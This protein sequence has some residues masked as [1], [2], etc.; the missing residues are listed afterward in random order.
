MTG[1]GQPPAVP[2]A[3]YRV[4][5]NAQ[6]TFAD[7][8]ALV[9]YLAR[10]GISHLYLSPFLAARTGSAHG[11]DIVDHNAFNPEL[12]GGEGFARLADT[13][14]RHG[15]GLIADFV[16]N[17]M[18]IA[19]ADNPWWLDMLEWGE[20]SPCAGYFDI[21]WHPQKPEL[22]GKVLLPFLGQPY[23]A[24]LESGQLRL[25]FDGRRGAFDVWYHE[26]RFP[27]APARFSIVLKPAAA[28]LRDSQASD[29]A[30]ALEAIANRLRA[31]GARAESAVRR[32]AQRRL[33][34]DVKAELAR[35]SAGDSRVARAIE[36]A[37]VP[38]NGIAGIP[39]SF[40]TL[41]RL[42]EA[43]VYRLS[44]WRVATHEINYRRFFDIND[45][46]GLRIEAPELFDDV[47]RLIFR[48]IADGDI[49]GLRIDHIDGLYDPRGYCDDLQ[50][51]IAAIRHAPDDGNATPFY[52]VVEKILAR[53]EFLREDWPV[54]G[55]TGYE[56][57]NLVNGLFVDPAA[58]RALTR[59]YRHV[60]RETQDFDE[61]LYA[62]K[63]HVIE[64]TLAAELR[65]LGNM[66]D[67]LSES[68]WTTRDFTRSGL[69]AALAE[70]VAC[71]PVYRTYVTARGIRPED[72]RDID[73]AVGAARR[74]NPDLD[75]SIFDFIH[76]LMTLDV[77][78]ARP[79]LFPRRAVIE[80]AMKLQ[81]YTGPVMAKAMEDTAFYR[82]HRLVSLN[83]V[84]GDPRQF[85]ISIAAFHHH[86]LERQRRRPYAML[87][88]A[89][90]D[91][92]RGEDTRT[93]ID[94]LTE[95]PAEWRSR[96][97][98]WTALNRR[99]KEM[100]D[101]RAVPRAN[102][103]YL[104]YQTLIG[105]WPS[106]LLEQASPASEQV[107]RFAERITAYMTKAVREAKRDS[108]WA[109]P[110]EPYEAA[111]GRFVDAIL[112]TT[113]PNPFLADF[114]AFQARI[115]RIGAIS[116]L[117]QTAI[118]VTAPGVPDSYRGG[119]LWDLS[120]VDPDNRRPVDY[121]LRTR[122]LDALIPPAAEEGAPCAALIETW[123]DGRIKLYILW[124]LLAARRADPALFLDGA[125][126]PLEVDGPARDR[127]CA[128]A[129]VSGARACL[130]VVPRLVA[131]FLQDGRL[132]PLSAG[133]WED[134]HLKLPLP[135]AGLRY[136][137]LLDGN[138]LVPGASEEG[139]VV[140]LEILFARF[141]VAV[142]L[143][144]DAA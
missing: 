27:I 89:T 13:A 137:G 1:P 15:L 41:H 142:L 110:N 39:D 99:R 64:N 82:Y 70:I 42:L 92:K 40:R 132:W 120:L 87:T 129:R 61:V 104:L 5:L 22:R 35:L 16:P 103:E 19:K 88:T 86:N 29:A 2:V 62:C 26:H 81:Q 105:A 97:R 57:C 114:V 9:P 33:G 58:E 95:L 37:L 55:T 133:A 31:L 32:A 73:W 127:V 90:H 79:R 66:L 45:L 77:N 91:T 24:V 134:S 140:P 25:A 56:F 84:G 63:K 136:R 21:D 10:L 60:T 67:R 124:R 128:Y 65:V 107:R 100:V 3:T 119:D 80:F 76:G 30:D 17:H 11:Y 7:A 125:Y 135:L 130:V 68:S 12:G 78:T 113:K 122:L 93:R 94:A 20:A 38:L 6:F 48:L 44:H 34:E 72:R 75:P 53:H 54:A 131:P 126:L 98:R 106:D 36:E 115:A 101:D 138:D 85:G 18:G 108:S 112:D 139:G 116:S 96:V 121:A 71:F 49:Q 43:Q 4:Q 14:R 59:C 23:G 144:G 118:R 47:H 117:A 8:S 28:R 83:E 69:Q 51:R 109:R 143:A 46:A 102:D 52:I 50:R 141:P 123:R 111:L 74:R